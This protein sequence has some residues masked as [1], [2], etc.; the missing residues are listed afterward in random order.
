MQPERMELE[1]HFKI[2]DNVS[3]IRFELGPDRDG[4]ECIEIKYFEDDNLEKDS[5]MFD[6]E[7]AMLVRDALTKLLEYKEANSKANDTDNRT[8]L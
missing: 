2:W 6:Y 1:L 7:T 4:N 5:L 8:T 3:G